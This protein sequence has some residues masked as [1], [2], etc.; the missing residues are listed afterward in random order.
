MSS[1]S[2]SRAGRSFREE[3]FQDAA[4]IWGEE[5]PRWRH[6]AGA[7]LTDPGLAAAALFRLARRLEDG[8]WRRTSSLIARL[9]LA[10]HGC[11]IHSRAEIGSGLRLPHPSGVVVGRGVRAGPDLTLYQNVTL[12]ARRYQDAD[13]PVLGEGV[14]VYPNCVVAGAIRVG[15]RSQ[16]GAGSVLLDDVAP[17]TTVAGAPAK[18]LPLPGRTSGSAGR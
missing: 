16:V 4:R 13:Y 10:L 2:R 14:V 17:G 11:Q 15:D 9:N 7:C 5:H 18:P 12:G 6:L 3:V 8:G 1:P